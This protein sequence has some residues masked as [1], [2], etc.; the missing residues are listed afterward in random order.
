MNMA[1]RMVR[2]AA[3]RALRTVYP[4][5]LMD[6]IVLPLEDTSGAIANL[7]V[8]HP[9]ER[10]T[11]TGPDDAFLSTA[12][13]YQD[14][15]FERP[16]IFV[17]EVPGGY[18]H[19]RSGMTCTRD[20]RLLIDKGLEHRRYHYTQF[21]KIRPLRTQH[22]A[23]AVSSVIPC[24]HGN[25]WHW[26]IDGLP[27]ME[28]LAQAM[29]GEPLTIVAPTSLNEYQRTTLESVTPPNFSIQYLD[30]ETWVSADRLLWASMVSQLEM[31][32]LPRRYYDTIRRG[33]FERFGLPATH[34]K[35]ERI[36]ISRAGA[37]HRK[38]SNED[39]FCALIEPYGFRRVLLEKLS[40][41]EQVA[42]FHKAEYVIGP[43]GAGLGTM[44]FSGDAP[45]IA[46]Y[47]NREPPSYF[48][49]MACGMGQ[50]HHFV[51][52]DGQSE[53]DSFDA[54]LPAVKRIL[55]EELKLVPR[56]S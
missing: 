2:Q 9:A 14:G 36:Y 21:N 1:I 56:A 5:S 13:A 26:M 20:S 6:R 45:V 32:M 27:R 33:I 47:S 43:H 35:S 52:H 17:C 7:Q 44:V 22:I 15:T 46:L 12:K 50:P 54:N 31:G 34:T 48:H 3:G 49:S 23:G 42:L 29:K 53:E 25:F 39:A 55:E 30:G 37:Q 16:A 11:V 51:C 28:L 18:L 19:V 40:F 4:A 38:I 24:F 10:V 41:Q 8:I